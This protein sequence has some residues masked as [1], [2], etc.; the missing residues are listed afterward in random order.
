MSPV[1]PIRSIIFV[2]LAFTFARL[3]CVIFIRIRQSLLYLI[4]Q[5]IL[6]SKLLSVVL[7]AIWPDDG[8]IILSGVFLSQLYLS[9]CMIWF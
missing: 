9:I 6:V 5:K 7:R 8:L 4:G 3:L 2:S 1:F